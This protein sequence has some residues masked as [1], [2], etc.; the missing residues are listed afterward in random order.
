MYKKGMHKES[1]HEKGVHNRGVCKESVQKK[2]VHKKPF[3]HLALHAPL[4]CLC[5]D[6]GL[7]DAI[8]CEQG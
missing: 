6:E 4:L 5:M 3:T 1:V 2:G 8:A 7:G